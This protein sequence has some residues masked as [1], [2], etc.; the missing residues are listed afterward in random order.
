[1]GAKLNGKGTVA[2]KK[3]LKVE[4]AGAICSDANGRSARSPVG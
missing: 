2:R 4:D 3:Q 1:M